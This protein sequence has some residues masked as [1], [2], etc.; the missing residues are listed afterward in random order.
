MRDRVKLIVNN[1]EIKKR[2]LGN[3]LIWQALVKLETTT[4]AYVRASFGEKSLTAYVGL[5]KGV[6]DVKMISFGERMIHTFTGIEAF[7]YYTNIKFATA[8]ELK[9]VLQKLGWEVRDGESKTG[10][11]ITTWRD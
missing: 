11:V 4:P 3:R 1:R 2:Y 9:N 10:I 8:E 5:K 6:N 7:S